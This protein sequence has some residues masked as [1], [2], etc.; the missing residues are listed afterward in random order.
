MSEE[1]RSS[2][3]RPEASLGSHDR[4]AVEEQRRHQRGSNA[5]TGLPRQ[6][7]TNGSWPAAGT[8]PRP[9]LFGF[10][11]DD[12]HTLDELPKAVFGQ[13][14]KGLI[15]KLLPWLRCERSQILHV[16]SGAL[17]PGEG[18][19]VDIRPDAKPDILADGRD[20]PLADASVDAV[21]I[22]P[23]YT[24]QYAQDLYGVEYPRPAHLL[25]EAARVV[26]PCGR[27][28]FVHYLV[29]MPAP[30]TRLVKVMGLSSGLGFSMRAV[31]IFQ[32]DQAELP[33]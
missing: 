4:A 12:L 18:I 32:R 9:P 16:C 10:L 20:L 19:R 8:D 7:Q 17:P 15:A 33:L 3:R 30:G 27:I 26:K 21:L 6:R 25:R 22:D 23:P 13:Y 24:E 31:T 14:S 1:K 5:R 2:R 11:H 28:G 29:P